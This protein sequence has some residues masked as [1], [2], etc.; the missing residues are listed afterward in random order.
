MVFGGILNVKLAPIYS[1]CLFISSLE[2]H[3]KV[4]NLFR[5]LDLNARAYN[6]SCLGDVG[7][8]V[9]EPCLCTVGRVS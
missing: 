7:E 8:A 5:S 1:I 6:V 2:I 3:Y 9:A 4:Q